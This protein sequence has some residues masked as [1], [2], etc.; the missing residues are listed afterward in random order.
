MIDPLRDDSTPASLRASNAGMR[1][2]LYVAPY[3]SR[4]HGSTLDNFAND[5]GELSMR[6]SSR[7][8]ES[9][10]VRDQNWEISTA[11]RFIIATGDLSLEANCFIFILR[12]NC[13]LYCS[14][15]SQC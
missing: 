1:L 9:F 6:D 14:C 2:D 3:E 5:F 13:Q 7:R 15:T 10:P 8:R 12:F 4:S 11:L